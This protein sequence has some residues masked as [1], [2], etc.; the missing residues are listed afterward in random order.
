[1]TRRDDMVEQVC[2]P[3]VDDVVKVKFLRQ[4]CDH[5]PGN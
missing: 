1:M 4:V 3:A 5:T 2:E